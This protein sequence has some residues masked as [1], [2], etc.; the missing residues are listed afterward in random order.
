MAGDTAFWSKLLG[1]DPYFNEPF[2]VGSNIGGYELGLD[3]NAAIEG[4]K[5]P[6]TYWGVENIQKA[7]QELNAQGLTQQGK[8]KDVGLGIKMALL[9]DKNN[10][11]LGIIENPNFRLS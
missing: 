11:V 5:A 2:Y 8:I 7:V 4:S 1:L 6:V 3:Q 9:L 10:T